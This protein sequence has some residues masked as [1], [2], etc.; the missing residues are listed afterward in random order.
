MGIAG[1]TI[2][3]LVVT[4]ETGDA[5]EAKP[6]GSCIA[7]VFAKHNAKTTLIRLLI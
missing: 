5:A 6:S 3:A 2:N 7:K 1:S 4:S